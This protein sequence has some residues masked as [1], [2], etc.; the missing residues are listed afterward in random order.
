VNLWD[1]LDDIA[2]RHDVLRHSFY[3][4]WSEGTLTRADLAC[5]AG[6]Y[7]HAV[8]ALAD[9]AAS[10]ARSVDA[11]PDAPALDVHAAEER[12]HVRLWDEFVV[13]VGGPTDAEPA[14]GTR[15]CA[16]VWAGDESR[17]L[18]QTLTAM[19]AIESAQ[20]AISETKQRGLAR[21]YGIS[22]A[23]YFSVHRQLDVEHAA[24]ARQL[25]ARR[26][27]GA[28]ERALIDAARDALEA[29]WSL[30][31]GVERLIGSGATA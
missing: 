18:L 10:A 2:N 29:N 4:R 5:Y 23:E 28:D 7:R 9:A 31:D 21:H 12:D 24:H 13:A 8:V 11:G 1:R 27:G 30:L 16:S 20:P 14:G 3:V 6:Q 19:Y 26:L 15:A 25:I 22:E 17:P